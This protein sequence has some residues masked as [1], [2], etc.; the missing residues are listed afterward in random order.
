MTACLSAVAAS[1]FVGDESDDSLPVVENFT[2]HRTRLGGIGVIVE[3]T[4]PFEPGQD[5]S[6]GARIILSGD[7]V[8]QPM[9]LAHEPFAEAE[10]VMIVAVGKGY[11][12]ADQMGEAT[13]TALVTTVDPITIGHQPVQK[14]F[15]NEIADLLSP[16]AA[17]FEYRRGRT[18]GN[19]KPAQVAA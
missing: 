15:T 12:F 16:A 1:L 14:S 11:T 13:L 4:S 2:R 6:E 3:K 8:N 7:S 10:A 19:P 17:D 5:E 9:Q 18:Q